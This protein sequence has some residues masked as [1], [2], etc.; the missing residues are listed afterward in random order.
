MS[1]WGK[2]IGGAA[3]FALGGP[4]GALVGV[5]AGHFVDRA[6]AIETKRQAFAIALIVLCAKM[7]KA[8]GKVTRDEIDAFKRIFRVPEGEMAQVGQIF[9]EAR[10]EATGFEPY[11]EQVME[12][13]PHNRQVR[14]ELLAALFHIAQADGVI[15]EAERAYLKNVARI[16]EFDERDFERIFASHLGSD[17][18]DPYEILG[19][20]RSAGD[21]EVKS[22]Y[23]N[24]IR[25]NHPDRLM[26]E[27][28]PQ[29]MID[30]ANEKMAHINDAY[31]RVAKLRGM[32]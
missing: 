23:R 16:F 24:L 14:E 25:E 20:D 26:A 17:E 27:G 1:I 30:V 7:A 18:A 11:A 12:I 13:F 3:G 32:K 29:E 2:I 4:I 15:H 6:T 19:V 21:D 10:Q 9:D 8:D 28:L 22:A 31:D 5:A